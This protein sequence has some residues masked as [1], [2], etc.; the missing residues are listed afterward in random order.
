MGGEKIR[1]VVIEEREARGSE[2]LSVG[3]K[4]ASQKERDIEELLL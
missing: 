1:D 4:V 3:R 2:P